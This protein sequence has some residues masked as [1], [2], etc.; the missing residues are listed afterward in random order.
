MS[1]VSITNVVVHNNPSSFQSPFQFEIVF[2]CL[3]ELK[4]DLEWK[5]IYVGSAENPKFDQVL[6]TIF[7]GPVVPGSSRFI[8]QVPAADPSNIPKTDVLG[9]TVVLLT[10]SYRGKEFVRVGY[11]VNNEYATE[12][13]RLNPPETI[14]YDKIQRVILSDKPRVTRFPIEWDE[15]PRPATTSS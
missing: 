6:D 9:V 1:L 3:A 7:V 13:L 10:C 14:Q 4:E 5:V 2:D 11:Y 15:E 8:F 12:E